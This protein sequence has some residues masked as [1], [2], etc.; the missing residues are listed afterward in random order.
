M[1]NVAREKVVQYLVNEVWGP[2]LPID[3]ESCIDLPEANKDGS[4][5]IEESEKLPRIFD[6]ERGDLIVTGSSPKM[7]YGTGILH[8]VKQWNKAEMEDPDDPSAGEF[9]TNN[10]PDAPEVTTDNHTSHGAEEGEDSF[11]LDLSQKRKPSAMGFSSEIV[12]FEGDRFLIQFDGATYEQIK[13]HHGSRTLDGWRRNKFTLNGTFVWSGDASLLD[14]LIPVQV[15]GE[16]AELLSIKIRLRKSKI[17]VDSGMAL[18]LTIVAKNEAPEAKPVD[19]FQSELNFELDGSGYIRSSKHAV[20]ADEEQRELDH[21]YRH[22]ANYALGHGTSVTWPEVAEG[23]VLRVLKT[24]YLPMFYQEVLDFDSAPTVNMQVLATASRENLKTLLLPLVSGFEAWI[25]KEKQKGLESGG[26]EVVLADLAERATHILQR[27]KSGFELLTNSTDSSALTA[28]QLANKAMYQQQLNGKRA[29]RKWKRDNAKPFNVSKPFGIESGAE[30]T[31]TIGSWRPFQLAFL[32]AVIPGIVDPADAS[33]EEVDLIFFPTGGGK[34]EAYLGASAFSILFQ[35]LVGNTSEELGVNV[36]MRY[37]LRLLTIQQFERSS[38]LICALEEMRQADQTLLGTTPISI[39]VWLG[40]HTTPN[41]RA[42]ALKDLKDI[43]NRKEDDPNPFVLNRCPVCATEF[44]WDG[45]EWRGYGAYPK[46]GGTATLR[47]ICPN[48]VDCFFGSKREPL[49]IWITDEDVYDAKPSFIL[50]TVDKFAQMAWQEN[51]KALFN[52]DKNG[53]RVGPPPSLII[54]DELHLISGPLGSMVGLYEPVIEELCTDKRNGALIRPKVIASTATTRRFKEQIKSLYG[55]NNVMLFPQAISRANETYFSNITY[56]PDGTKKKGSLYIG[57]NPATYLNGQ[58]SAARIAAILKQAPNMEPNLED[59]DMDYYR[60]SM[61]F[62]N[63]LRELGMTYTLMLSTVRDFIGG[64]RK[65]NRLPAPKA[66]YPSKILELT[67]RIDSNKVSTSLAALGLP[68]WDP[69]S[70]DTCLASSI[71]EVG[72]DV[73]R[74]GLLTIMS[75]PKTTAQ[76]I[77]VSGRV[78]RSRDAG[79]GLIVMLYN[80]ARARDRSIYERFQPY[81]ETL[82]AQ[83]EPISLTPFAIEAMNHGLKGALFS[84]YRMTGTH[85]EK[86]NNADWERFA[87]NI[88]VVRQRLQNLGGTSKSLSDFDRLS[89]KLKNYWK[90][91]SPSEWSYPPEEEKNNHKPETVPALMRMRKE[92]LS[93]VHGDQSIKVPTS[94]RNVDGQT[95]LTIEKPYAFSEDDN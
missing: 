79:P 25:S 12:L 27:I 29:L 5:S 55:R 23:N 49:P 57:V 22:T 7:I 66:S 17:S 58:T 80:T 86:P 65:G 24:T 72:V 36:L 45:E 54:Q 33:R 85:G 76:Y 92:P 83:V 51:A 70:Y 26:D 4:F 67:S 71:M 59:P 68:S 87:R 35:R 82:Y 28:F 77:Q 93:L 13:L 91:Y 74:L 88:A 56:E 84:L 30:P 94:M 39:G 60:T 95:G 78:G 52:L 73:P 18:V 43:K 90:T 44:G 19:I 89:Q 38:G 1:V 41:K 69:K 21:L 2:V 75:Q 8:T 34:T 32:L 42:D 64:M 46:T 15:V 10:D 14:T 81:H 6:R 20:S 53:D 48:K 63:S 37:T 50:G 11:S 3:E 40:R 31:G 62:F 47:F 61:W 16:K 9:E